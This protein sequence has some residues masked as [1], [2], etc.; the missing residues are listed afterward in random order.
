MVLVILL[1]IFFAFL[2]SLLFT[3]NCEELLCLISFVIGVVLA[4]W[5]T[6]AAVQENRYDVIGSAEIVTIESGGYVKNG[7]IREDGKVI[8]LDDV[9]TNPEDYK[10]E[11]LDRQNWYLGIRFMD[12]TTHRVV[13][14]KKTDG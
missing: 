12:K 2:C 11:I 5:L 4:L 7:F 1:A 8:I 10:V 6:L 14:K 13:K 9:Y 3:D